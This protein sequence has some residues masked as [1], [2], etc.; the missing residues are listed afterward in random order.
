MI[1]SAPHPPRVKKN[2]PEKN[3]N[4]TNAEKQSRNKKEAV[5]LCKIK[6]KN[7]RTISRYESCQTQSGFLGTI[8][9]PMKDSKTK[10][11]LVGVLPSFLP[12]FLFCFTF[13]LYPVF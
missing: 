2:G 1:L 6:G 11:C 5:L 9:Q 7:S 10:S 3:P 13:V 8:P 4:K 12:P